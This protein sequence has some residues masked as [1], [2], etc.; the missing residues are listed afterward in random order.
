[1]HHFRLVTADGE[2]L[3]TIELARPD[4]PVGSVIHMNGRGRDL[5]VVDWVPGLDDPEQLA[6]LV[7]EKIRP[8]PI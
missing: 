1:M 2:P 8:Q 6:T 7:V 5:R 4:W 3:G